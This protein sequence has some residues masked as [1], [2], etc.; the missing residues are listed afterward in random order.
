MLV[1][2]ADKPFLDSLRGSCDWYVSALSRATL[3]IRFLAGEGVISLS[4]EQV[5]RF[6][7]CW[8]VHSLWIEL[9]RQC[10]QLC[11]G[12]G[13]GAKDI[14]KEPVEEGVLNLTRDINNR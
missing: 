13:V 14:A 7:C 2:E 11:G 10:G 6:G 8:K 5:R 9:L 4:S 1:A 3:M 12:A